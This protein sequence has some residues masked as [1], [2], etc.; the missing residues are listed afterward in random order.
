MV[1]WR[2]ERGASRGRF[3]RC[4]GSK[5]IGCDAGEACGDERGEASLCETL[6]RTTYLLRCTRDESA[7]SSSWTSLILLWP[8]I[9][10]VFQEATLKARKWMHCRLVAGKYL[11]QRP[12][13]Y[14]CPPPLVR[15]YPLCSMLPPSPPTSPAYEPMPYGRRSPSSRGSSTRIIPSTEAHRSC[16]A[17]EKS[18]APST[19]STSY[20]SLK[21]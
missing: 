6:R 20:H 13:R 1:A 16:M 11:H 7:S 15:S 10:K 18:S 14:L 8:A 3:D 2:E 5:R 21:S 9:G 4:D 12:E 19:P 17:S